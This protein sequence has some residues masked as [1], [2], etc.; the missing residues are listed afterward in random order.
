[1]VNGNTRM[2]AD[3]TLTVGGGTQMSDDQHRH[4]SVIVGMTRSHHHQAKQH[5][6]VC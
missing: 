4:D 6:Q 3:G 1:M 5:P 2:I